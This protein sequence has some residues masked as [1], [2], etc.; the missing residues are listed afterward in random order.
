MAFQFPALR[1]PQLWQRRSA[2]DD[3]AP[4]GHAPRSRV[5]ALLSQFSANTLLAILIG[6]LVA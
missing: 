2:V 1:L 6:L 3:N 4:A 5:T